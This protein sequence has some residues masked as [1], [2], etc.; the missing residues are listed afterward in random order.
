[1]NNPYKRAAEREEELVVFNDAEAN[2]GLLQ[3]WYL[4]HLSSK[5]LIDRL[6]HIKVNVPDR[7]RRY[8][9]DSFGEYCEDIS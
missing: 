7:I 8:K 2:E 4:G 3:S 1:M 6:E 9:E 5:E